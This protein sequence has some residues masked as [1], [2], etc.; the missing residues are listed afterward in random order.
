MIIPPAPPPLPQTQPSA[1]PQQN[2]QLAQVLAQGQTAAKGV[3]T[4]TARA[5]TPTGRTD[6]GRGAQDGTKSGHTADSEA[7]AVRAQTPGRA[8]GRGDKLDVS[9]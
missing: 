7:N 4:Q 2:T 3:Q 1:T 5:A 6:Q 9:I 8:P